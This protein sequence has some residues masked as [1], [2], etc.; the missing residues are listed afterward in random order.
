M[1]S[2]LLADTCAGITGRSAQYYVQNWIS[3]PY[4]MNAG[5]VEPQLG[6]IGCPHK[7]WLMCHSLGLDLEAVCRIRHNRV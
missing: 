6:I 2:R 4:K 3:W 7:S 1:A 5:I